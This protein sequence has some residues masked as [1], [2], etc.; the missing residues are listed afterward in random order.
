MYLVKFQDNYIDEF[1][2]YGF[3]LIE[4]VDKAIFE[5]KVNS[6]VYPYEQF[7]GSNQTIIYDSA[8]EFLNHLEWIYID[9]I[10]YT[11]LQKHFGTGWGTNPVDFFF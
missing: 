6:Q 5:K 11:I 4:D 10:Q 9:E 2:I 7:I 1:N 3:F 8:Q